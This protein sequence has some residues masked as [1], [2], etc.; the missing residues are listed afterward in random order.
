MNAETL[1]AIGGIVLSLAFGFIPGLSDWYYKQVSQLQAAIMLAIL[2]G[3]SAISF[4]AGCVGFSFA[5]GLT[6]DQ[7][8]LETVLTALWWAVLSNQGIYQ[9]GVKPFSR[10]RR[11]AQDA[12]TNPQVL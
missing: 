1:G 11:E 9:I 12:R 7:A 6:C 3:L 10:A 2:T 8:G 4:G 5:A